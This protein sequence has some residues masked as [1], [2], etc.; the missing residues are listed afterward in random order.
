VAEEPVP[1]QGRERDPRS[2]IGEGGVWSP[3]FPGQRRPFV[4][5]DERAGA[6]VQHGAYHEQTVAPIAARY[7]ERLLALAPTGDEPADVFAFELLARQLAKLE[8]VYD[9]LDANGWVDEHGKP[10]PAVQLLA[11]WENTVR[12]LIVELG[13]TTLSRERIGELRAST[14]ML[15]SFEEAQAA[16]VAMFQVAARSLELA[17]RELQVEGPVAEALQRR[18]MEVFGPAAVDSVSLM[19]APVGDAEIEGEAVEDADD[20]A[21]GEGGAA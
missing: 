9:W 11:T 13:L 4:L 20:D 10:R 6:P 3:A 7:L 12:K 2:G 21:S 19:P 14:S 15:I 18:F 17:T 5:G 16:F 8:L 1:E